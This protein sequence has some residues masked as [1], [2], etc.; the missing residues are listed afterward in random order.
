MHEIEIICIFKIIIIRILKYNNIKICFK[1]QI[2]LVIL[3]TS[4]VKFVRNVFNIKN[5]N[6][7][8]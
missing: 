6:N 4:H 1:N 2:F 3:I 5:K 7:C 8:F